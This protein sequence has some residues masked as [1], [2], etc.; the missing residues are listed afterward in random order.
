MILLAAG[1]CAAAIAGSANGATLQRKAFLGVKMAPPPQQVRGVLVPEVIPGGTAQSI[2]V[3]AGDIIVAA[4][5]RAVAQPG[6]V[7]GYAAS[8]RGGDPADLTV[9]RDGKSIRLRGKA[10]ARPYETFANATVDYG[11]VPF[12]GGLIRDIMVTPNGVANPPVLFLIQGFSCGSI[13]PASPDNPY[14]HLGGE[15]VKR[16]IGY[17]RVEKPGDGD[18]AGTP[19]C[20][21]IDLTTEID[22]FRSAYRHLVEKRHVDPDRIFIL[23]WS[24]GGIEAPVLAA[25]TPPRGVAAYGTV[26][27]NWADYHLDIDRVQSF[28]SNG[29]DPTQTFAAAERHR[30]LIR[31]FYFGHETPA[32]LAAGNPEYAEAMR[33]IFAWDGTDKMF[34]RNFRYTQEIADLPLAKF[35]RA[36]KSNVLALYGES[37]IVAL[38]GEDHRLIADIANYFRPGSGKF[39]EVPGTTHGMELVGTRSDYREKA[40]RAG[41]PPTGPFNP[42]VAADLADW[43]EASMRRPPVRKKTARIHLRQQANPVERLAA[44]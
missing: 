7:A 10:K 34:G 25:E 3:D 14:R 21:D 30:D 8:L 6:D 23:G 16:R 35:W 44:D 37:D 42:Q 29:E 19:A 24:L 27:R 13:E 18:S 12:R 32:A 4:G 11:A 17:Y 36:T 15:L 2:G 26:L 43:I 33:N 31:R 41:A 28:L 9:I 40:I 5:G 22:S 39:V 20:A 38:N 1:F